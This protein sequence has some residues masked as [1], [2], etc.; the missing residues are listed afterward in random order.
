MKFGYCVK[1]SALDARDLRKPLPV[2]TVC[3]YIYKCK[4]NSTMQSESN[5]Y[6]QRIYVNPETLQASLR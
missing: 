6:Q 4:C 1:R 5:I 2:N 3:K